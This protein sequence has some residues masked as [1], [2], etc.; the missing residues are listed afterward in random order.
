LTTSAST[1]I[2][3]RPVRDSFSKGLRRQGPR[4]QPEQQRPRS[5]YPH[6]G[7]FS[8]FLSVGPTVSP[9]VLGELLFLLPSKR[10]HLLIDESLGLTCF[11][12]GRNRFFETQ[13]AFHHSFLL[14]VVLQGSVRT[15]EDTRAATYTVFQVM[16]N[17]L[18]PIFS[19]QASADAGFHTRSRK[20]MLT[21]PYPRGSAVKGDGHSVPRPLLAGKVAHLRNPHGF[22]LASKHARKTCQAAFGMEENFSLHVTAPPGPSMLRGLESLSSCPTLEPHNIRPGA[23]RIPPALVSTLCPDHPVVP[24]RRSAVEDNQIPF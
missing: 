8:F 2:P 1:F 22:H 5:P 16:K 13:V 23:G 21:D 12:A 3:Q 17:L 14:L 24:L 20:A 9:Q 10:V 19:A 11:H 4:R 15:N 6:S 7:S 18:A